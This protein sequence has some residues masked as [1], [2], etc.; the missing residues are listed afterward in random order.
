MAKSGCCFHV[1]TR[2]AVVAGEPVPVESHTEALDPDGD[3][4]VVTDGKRVGKRWVETERK[5]KLTSD[6]EAN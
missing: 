5:T 2:Y 1:W 3:E 4:L 6:A